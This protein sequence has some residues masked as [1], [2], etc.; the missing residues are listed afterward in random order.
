MTDSMWHWCC[1]AEAHRVYAADVGIN[2]MLWHKILICPACCKVWYPLGVLGLLCPLLYSPFFY[3]LHPLLLQTASLLSIL[4]TERVGESRLECSS[5]LR[6]N[7]EETTINSIS[8]GK[9][10]S[11]QNSQY[12][13]MKLPISYVPFLPPKGRKE[14]EWLPKK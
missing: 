9:M 12:M 11:I 14:H 3:S 8:K 2:S 5:V 1:R 10:Q 4:C 7:I 13:K 6:E